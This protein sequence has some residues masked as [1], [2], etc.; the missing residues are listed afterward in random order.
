LEEADRFFHEDFLK[1]CARAGAE[2]EAQVNAA[3]Q[4]VARAQNSGSPAELEA[5]QKHLAQVQLS[6][7]EKLKEIAA[8]LQL[9]VAAFQLLKAAV[10]NSGK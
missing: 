8:H 10:T 4:E 6:R 3:Q 5:A 9:Q 2:L 1:Q 7:A